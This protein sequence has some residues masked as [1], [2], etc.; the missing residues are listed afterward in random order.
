MLQTT[1]NMLVPRAPI[2][3]LLRERMAQLMEKR[4][5]EERVDRLTKTAIEAIQEI[6]EAHMTGLFSDTVL[7]AIHAKRVTIMPKDMRLAMRLRGDVKCDS[8]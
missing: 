4:P 8:A 6:A 1:T 2:V 5:E 7:C 3:R